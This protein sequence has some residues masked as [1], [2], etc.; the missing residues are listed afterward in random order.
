M[1]TVS[2]QRNTVTES[3]CCRGSPCYAARIGGGEQATITDS[4]V[5]RLRWYSAFGL[6]RGFEK[7][8]GKLGLPDGGMLGASPHSPNE[9]QKTS[10]GVRSMSIGR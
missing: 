9:F 7:R 8:T 3:W 10:Y 1:F 4:V 5:G 2:K 6:W